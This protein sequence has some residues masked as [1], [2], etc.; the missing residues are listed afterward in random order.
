MYPYRKTGPS[1]PNI[2][3]LMQD[4]RTIL[5]NMLPIQEGVAILPNIIQDS[6]AIAPSTHHLSIQDGRSIA[7]NIYPYNTAG[8]YPTSTHT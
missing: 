3:P 2:Y 7:P 8:L 5:P 4:G 1:Y 6:R